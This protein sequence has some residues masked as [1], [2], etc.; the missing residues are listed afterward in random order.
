MTFPTITIA[1]AAL[2][3]GGGTTKSVAYPA[4]SSGHVQVAFLNITKDIT[5]TPPAGEGWAEDTGGSALPTY[6]DH[7]WDLRIFKRTLSGSV[8][9][10]SSTWTFSATTQGNIFIVNSTGPY[11]IAA[12]A[13]ISTFQT[14]H[15]LPSV[16]PTGGGD[17]LWFGCI[18][19]SNWPR[20][21]DVGTSGFTEIGDVHDY[22]AGLWLGYKNHGLGSATG[23][24]GTITSQDPDTLD[25]Q[26]ERALIVSIIFGPEGGGGGGGGG[27]G[28]IPTLSGNAEM[29]SHYAV[30]SLASTPSGPLSLSA[31]TVTNV[32]VVDQNGLELDDQIAT[33]A[34]SNTGVATVSSP[35][36][37]SGFFSLTAVANGS[38]NVT[39]SYKDPD[40]GNTVQLVIAVTVTGALSITTSSLPAGTVGTSYSQTVVG[41]GAGTF[42]WSTVNL[43]PGLAINASTGAITGTPTLEGIYDVTVWLGN[44]TTNTSKAL[45]LKINA[46]AVT[47]V[48]GSAWAP[49]IRS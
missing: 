39:V 26:T 32:K 6:T 21:H 23:S 3:G 10:G 5:V 4:G 19:C 27:G 37:S 48:T 31:G 33:V 47:S 28:S 42:A 24:S 29:P 40:T 17:T 16:T 8:S 35:V 7:F 2:M 9:A 15:F 36:N 45:Q 46:E 43:P 25:P 1:S 49:L 44:G 30:T 22:V 18:A 38:A 14:N 11:Q 12:W 13:Q 41:A 20:T 34:S